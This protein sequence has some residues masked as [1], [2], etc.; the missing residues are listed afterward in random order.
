M[1]RFTIK[2][3]TEK[4]K[5]FIDECMQKAWGAAAHAAW[6]E[7]TLNEL[8]AKYQDF[9]KQDRAIDAEMK[10]SLDAPD[11]HTVENRNK[12]AHLQKERNTISSNMK[13]IGKNMKEGTET[14]Q[15]LLN[16]TDQNLLLADFAKEWEWKEVEEKPTVDEVPEKEVAE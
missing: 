4:R 14:M 3:Q 9:Q 13:L 5:A 12:R 7:K 10:L 1:A 16:S 8:I 15:R 2:E 6:I 11:H